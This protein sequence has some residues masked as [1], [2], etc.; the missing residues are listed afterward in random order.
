MPT[1]AGKTTFVEH[2]CAYC[3]TTFSIRRAQAEKSQRFC[4]QSCGRLGSPNALTLAKQRMQ[5]A[6]LRTVIVWDNDGIRREHV[7]LDTDETLTLAASFRNLG[8]TRVQVADETGP[9]YGWRRSTWTVANT[10]A[11]KLPMDATP[12]PAKLGFESITPNTTASVEEDGDQQ[13]F[14]QLLDLRAT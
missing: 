1:R 8:N 10:W 11:A 6:E 4:S 3:N 9:L 2:V 7:C 14:G 12:A 13:R 5:A